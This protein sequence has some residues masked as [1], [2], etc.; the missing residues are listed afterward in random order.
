MLGT[1]AGSTMRATVVC[2]S[3]AAPVGLGPDL[4]PGLQR[5]MGRDGPEAPVACLGPS[6]PDLARPRIGPLGL[7]GLPPRFHQVLGEL[8]ELATGAGEGEALGVDDALAVAV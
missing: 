2:R 5:A 1:V 8:L 7:G 6:R 3:P 4:L